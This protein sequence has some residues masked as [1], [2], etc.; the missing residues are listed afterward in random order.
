MD[1]NKIIADMERD[2]TR[3]DPM[4][5]GELRGL[6]RSGELSERGYVLSLAKGVLTLTERETL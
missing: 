5:V 6:V 4:F 3:I 1:F 2:I